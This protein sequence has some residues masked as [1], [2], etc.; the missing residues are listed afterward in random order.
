MNDEEDKEKEEEVTPQNAHRKVF[1]C[2]DKGDTV[3]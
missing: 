2:G 3:L 1:Q